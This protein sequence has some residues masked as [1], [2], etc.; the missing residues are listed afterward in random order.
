MKK[1]AFPNENIKVYGLPWFYDEGEDQGILYRLPKRLQWQLS[2]PLWQ[3]ASELSG[4]RLRFRSDTTSLRVKAD[5][6]WDSDGAN[7]SIRGRCGFDLYADGVFW[8]I[9]AREPD[10]FAIDTELFEGAEKKMREFEL[11]LPLDSSI[12]L[13]ELQIDDD[14]VLLPSVQQYQ[15]ANPVFFYGTSITQ[16]R[17]AGKPGMTYPAILSRMHNIDFVNLGFAGRGR[18]ESCIAR[19]MAHRDAACYVLDF[20]QNNFGADH[21]NDVYYP[22]IREIKNV[23]PG[24]PM[25]LISAYW[26][27]EESYSRKKANEVD[28][29]REVVENT[30][31]RCIA[32]G[33]QNLCFVD[34]KTL[35]KPGENESMIDGV[36]PTDWGY[37]NIAERLAPHIL[38]VI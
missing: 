37:Y 13:H 23:K 17:C 9:C 30:Y 12:Q 20:S 22:F 34:G 18:G 6:L 11:Y 5:Y 3:R 21:L 25:I 35:L 24:V 33:M 8:N 10:A 38:R 4:A 16:G 28:A 15:N 1:I 29:I 31:E 19:E 14:A 36:H 7:R 27:A 2:A 26:Q 32:E